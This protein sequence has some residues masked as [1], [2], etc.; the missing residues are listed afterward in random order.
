MSVPSLS[1][2]PP[3]SRSC[4]QREGSVGNWIWDSINALFTEEGTDEL[5]QKLVDMK[6]VSAIESISPTPARGFLP[7]MDGLGYEEVDDEDISRKIILTQLGLSRSIQE[8]L[9]STKLF[10]KRLLIL[11]RI[12]FAMQNQKSKVP[13]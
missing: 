5:H 12:Y 10:K 11:E 13:S 3:T 2:A 6:E 4:L 1:T 9:D 7:Q 8:N